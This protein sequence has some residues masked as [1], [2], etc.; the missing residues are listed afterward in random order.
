MIRNNKTLKKVL[1][2]IITT[3]FIF[4]II[5]MFATKVIY[6]SVFIR[7]NEE[8]RTVATELE[9][10][11]EQRQSVSYPSGEY[12]LQG[13]LYDGE[14]SARALIVIA[15]GFHATADDYLWQ[16]KELL[17]YGWAVFAFDPT[18]SGNSEGDSS[19]GFPQEICDV[20]ATLDYL[21]GAEYF[22]Y[23]E[24]FLLGHSRGGYAVC[25]V[26]QYDYDVS[27][28]VS[29]SGINS[30]MDGIMGSSVDK[31]G[32]LAYGNYP[33]LWLYQ[34][35]LFGAEMTNLK[36]SEAISDADIP[37]LI[38]QGNADKIATKDKY[39]IYSYQDKIQSDCVEYYVCEEPK[40]DGH[41]SLLYDSDGTANDELM[42]AIHTF[43][44]AALE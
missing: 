28:V 19:I 8:N 41:T 43:F 20:Q 13:Y 26:L 29:V 15:P 34:S 23:E 37:V 33:F 44:T 10:L 9:Y 11:L 36:A 16:I 5:S 1:V 2:I 14:K 31:V 3:L 40:Y 6:D 27:G 25:S 17:D 12:K 42:A 24:L 22:G 7:K 4:S 18:G 39:S 35:M 32:P 30:A 21:E 38:V